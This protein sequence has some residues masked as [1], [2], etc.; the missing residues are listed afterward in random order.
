MKKRK[1]TVGFH[2]GVLSTLPSTLKAY[3]EMNL[4]SLINMWLMGSASEGITALG[5][6]NSSM[7]RHFDKEG[8]RLSR[9]RR[10]MKVVEIF[11]KKRGVGGR[12]E[13]KVTGTG[14]LVLRFGMVFR[15]TSSPC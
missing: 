15:Q 4:E 5:F 10:L 13:Q 3:P 9:M 1:M 11:A 2:H 8:M 7:V 12:V 14:L 6:L